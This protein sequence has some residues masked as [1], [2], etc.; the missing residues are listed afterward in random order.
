MPESVNGIRGEYRRFT[1]VEIG[2]V[3][4]YL[5]ESQGVKRAALAAEANVSEKTVERAEAGEGVSEESCRRIARALGLKDDAFIRELYIPT[6]EEAEHIQR[7]A[8]EERQRTHC[9]VPV[10]ELHSV[11]D[12]LPLFDGYALVGDDQCVLE[13]H[14]QRFAELKQTLLDWADIF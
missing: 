7:Q 8:L 3:I 9:V 6:P 12:V 2:G 5:R 11:R 1:S 14:L 4:R 13:A 10:R